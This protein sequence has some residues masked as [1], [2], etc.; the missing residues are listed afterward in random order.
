MEKLVHTLDSG[1][2]LYQISPFF[3]KTMNFIEWYFTHLE[4]KPPNWNLLM[5]FGQNLEIPATVATPSQCTAFKST[6]PTSRKCFQCFLLW[7]MFIFG[8]LFIFKQV[9]YYYRLQ[10]NDWKQFNVIYLFYIYNLFVA[11]SKN[12][13]SFCFLDLQS[14]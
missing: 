7:Q 3:T 14:Y 9:Q 13:F 1:V 11:K 2:W 8:L 5:L 4:Y 6:L 12:N 10:C